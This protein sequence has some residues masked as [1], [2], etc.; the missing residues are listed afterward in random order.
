MD[1]GRNE[2]GRKVAARWRPMR[3]ADL[4][5][6]AALAAA[7]HPDHPERPEVFAERLTLAPGSCRVLTGAGDGGP[8]LLGYAVAHPW[9]AAA[10]P[11]PL[12]ALLGA[13]PPRPDS[14]HLHDVVLHPAARGAGHAARLLVRRLAAARAGGLDLATLVAVAG[15]GAYWERQGF[16]PHPPGDAIALASYGPGALFMA[17]RLRPDRAALPHATPEGPHAA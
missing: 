12:D 3:P 14:W 11:P 10:G 6:V 16:R 15:K 2:A 5:H 7:A 4:P 17:R 9:A 1:A 13:L 8:T